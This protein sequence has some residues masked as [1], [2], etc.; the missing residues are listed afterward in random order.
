MVHEA[1]IMRLSHSLL[2]LAL[3]TG[4][5]AQQVD[6]LT[7]ASIDFNMNPGMPDEVL[8]SAPGFLA[9]L[10]QLDSQLIYGQRLYG[11][12]AV[13][14]LD[15]ATGAVLWSC[16]LSQ[17]V[18]P[19]AAVVSPDGILYISGSYMD[20]M[21]LCDGSAM[22][23][24]GG[25]FTENYF[26]VAFDMGSA[27]LLWER[28]LSTS[29]PNASDIPSLAV[30]HDGH[31]WY[32]EEEWGMARVIRVDA[33]GNDVETRLIDGV[34]RIGTIS[35]DPGG[36]MYVS[37][38]TDDAGFAFGGSAYQ[39][40]SVTGYR[41]FVLRY[42][43]DGTA[44]FAR[45][46]TDQTFQNPTVVATSDGHAYL[47]GDLLDSTTWGGNIHFHGTNWV[48]D[49]FI[50]KLDS[51]GQFLWGVESAPSGGPITGDMYRAKG[52]CIAVD[53]A[54]NAFF[55]GTLRGLVDWGNGVVSDGLTFGVGTL[56]IVGFAPDGTPLWARTS[57]PNGGFSQA[58]TL[59]A[60]AEAGALH[61]AGHIG[62]EFIFPPE[63]TNTGGAQAAMVGRISG[64][65]MGTHALPATDGLL[66]WPNPTTDVLH[67]TWPGTT[68]LPAQLLNSAGRTLRHFSLKPGTNTIPSDGLPAGVY[69]IRVSDGTTLRLVKQ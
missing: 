60:M 35:C 30:D 21:Q 45:F 43:P 25:Q 15:P 38:A 58:Q 28:G 62:S 46:A 57:T 14:R 52:P 56:T 49:A 64:L 67:I 26:I 22:S 40:T 4:L 51:T 66:A 34:R 54:D 5:S 53:P 18:H 37:G 10:R 33:M 61:F 13:E 59:T 27:M 32:A 20:D 6:W 2:S 42:R 23:G 11:T 48:Y 3:C 12:L 47:G 68:T 39:P 7:S 41:M 65:S 44:G 29:Y 19:S 17:K 36:G 63:T 1:M 8:A 31:L 55:M 16:Q 69:L 9:H 24:L 50:T